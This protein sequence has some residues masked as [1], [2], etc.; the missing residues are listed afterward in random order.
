MGIPSGIDGLPNPGPLTE[1]QK[2]L[3]KATA[4]ILEENGTTITKRFYKQMLDGNPELKN[5]F[6][7]SKQQRGDQAEALARAVYAYAANI[8]D[9][10]PIIPVVDRLCN[11]HASLH[12]VPH[13]Y[14]IIGSNLLKAIADVLGAD[15]FKGELYEAWVAAYW[16]LA[17][18]L[19]DRESAL[20]R[21]AGWEGW[22]EFVVDK[23]IKEADDVTSFYLAPKDRTPLPVHRPGQ[24]ISVQKYITELGV[25]QS[26]QYSLSDSHHPDYFRISVKRDAGV[27]AVDPATGEVDVS[28]AGHLGW[29]SNLLHDKLNEGD[30]IEVTAPFGDFFLDDTNGP[31]VLISAGVGVTPLASMLH[32]ILEHT[33]ESEARRLVSWIQ[34]VRSRALHPLRKEVR[35]LLKSRPEQVRSAIFY[36]APSAEEVEGEEYDFRGR[37]DLDCVEPLLHLDNYNAHYYLCGPERFMVEIG[38]KLKA[39]GIGPSRIHAEVFGQGAVPL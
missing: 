24:Y 4:P 29:M 17:H 7:H 8:D 25:L 36:S 18:L 3:V 14:A 6:N 20:Y 35:R 26:R 27:R 33:T 5:V 15:V 1:S 34:V 31:A 39:K 11:K 9:L 22:K 13:Q 16:Q 23:K 30:T 32:T 21:Q 10:T 28:Q 2:K 19:I 38:S 12:V 37:M